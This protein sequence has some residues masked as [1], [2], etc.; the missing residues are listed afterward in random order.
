[1]RSLDVLASLDYRYTDRGIFRE[2]DLRPG[3]AVGANGL[4]GHAVG[5]YRMM[6]NLIHLGV[7][8]LQA[9][10]EP[11]LFVTDVGEAGELVGGEE[12]ADAVRELLRNIG[13]VIPKRF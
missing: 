4:H 12:M 2:A 1:M 10:R 11:A 8:Q 6:A 3:F 13:R 7:R 5:Q 9:G